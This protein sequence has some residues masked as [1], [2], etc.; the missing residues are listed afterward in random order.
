[1]SEAS[2]I[3]FPPAAKRSSP[4][5]AAL[6]FWFFW[7]KPK[8]QILSSQKKANHSQGVKVSKCQDVKMK[9]R[10]GGQP[11]NGLLISRRQLISNPCRPIMH[12]NNPTAD[13]PT[14]FRHML[15]DPIIRMRIHPEMRL[16][17]MTPSEALIPNMRP[18][19]IRSQPMNHPI[20]LIIQPGT[21]FD[22]PVEGIRSRHEA[23]GRMNATL[24]RI[25]HHE[26]MPLPNLP[27]DLLLRRIPVDPL[28]RIPA[29]RHERPSIRKNLHQPRQI[30]QRP[31]PNLQFHIQ[32]HF[33]LN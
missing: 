20:R 24:L 17:R 6:T 14:L 32:C 16:L 18:C 21:P 22:H 15:Q 13:K 23:E 3:H 27:F 31:L 28:V 4:D 30:G 29:T 12:I 19:P 7:V 26:T 9:K 1:M 11:P 2:F 33:I 25:H 5:G 10:F 8:E